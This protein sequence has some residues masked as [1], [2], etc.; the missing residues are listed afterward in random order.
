MTIYLGGG[1]TATQESQVWRRAL[2]G[3]DRL[4]YWPFA[5]PDARLSDAEAWLTSSLATLDID[6]EV[7]TWHSLADHSPAELTDYDFLFVGGGSTSKLTHHIRD[8]EY[9]Q[10][11]RNYLTTGGHYYGGSAGAILTADSIGIAALVDEDT[12]AADVRGLGLIREVSVFPHA[13]L[14]SLQ[15][16]QEV[17]N[18]LGHD[19]LL[20]PEASGAVFDGQVLRP[21]GP[22]AVYMLTPDGAR[23]RLRVS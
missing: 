3:V 7:A 21:I 19:V 8:H 9:G 10:A 11:I 1:G 15:R 2:H 22:D 14:F 6:V 18:A 12:E 13:D 20:L 16:Q 4:L 17:A 23:S 5:L